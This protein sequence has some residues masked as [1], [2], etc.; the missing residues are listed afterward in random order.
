MN[1][2]LLADASAKGKV[3]KIIRRKKVKVAKARKGS[4]LKPD[5]DSNNKVI[6]TDGNNLNDSY[7]KS[8]R[9]NANYVDYSDHTPDKFQGT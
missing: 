8:S 1:N 7:W 5:W 9:R 2:I 4:M 6:A 3:K